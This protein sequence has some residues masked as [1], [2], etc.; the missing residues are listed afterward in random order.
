MEH[1][2][3]TFR[4]GEVVLDGDTF[5][6]C[7]FLECRL[8]FYSSKPC[9]LAGCTFDQVAWRV[10]GSAAE[11]FNFLARLYHSGGEEGRRLVEDTFDSIRRGLRW[12]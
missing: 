11:T 6:G 1:R 12:P 8:V 5:I 4:R 10:Y 3:T 2:D 7:S 9:Y